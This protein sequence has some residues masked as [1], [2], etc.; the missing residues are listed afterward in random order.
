VHGIFS[1]VAKQPLYLLQTLYQYQLAPRNLE[2][3]AN[4]KKQRRKLTRR[5]NINENLQKWQQDCRI[6]SVM[7]YSKYLNQ[8][9][10]GL[11]NTVCD[12]KV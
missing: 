7:L 2:T 12:D 4:I 6:Y 10:I 3:H 1:T 8:R 11:R 9:N 5:R